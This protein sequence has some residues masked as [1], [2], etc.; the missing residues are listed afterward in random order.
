MHD[1][2]KIEFIAKVCH[3]INRAYCASIGD[4]SHLPWE[5]TPENIKAS[6]RAGVLSVLAY[7]NIQPGETHQL[8]LEFKIKDGWVYG[9][10]K[11]LEKKT[12]PCLVPYEQL[13]QADRTKDYLFLATI[14][15]LM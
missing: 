9:A 12:H 6:A 10:V 2:P 5:E 4:H 8:W 3:E 14:K 11:D 13:S 7:P 1:A 15:Q